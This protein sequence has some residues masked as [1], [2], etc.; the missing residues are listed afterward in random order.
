LER[1]SE[2][3]F[4]RITDDLAKANSERDAALMEL[5]AKSKELS[6]ARR[7]LAYTE[8]ELE[9]LRNGRDGSAGRQQLSVAIDGPRD[10]GAHDERQQQQQQHH[11]HVPRGDVAQ[12]SLENEGRLGGG[13]SASAPSFTGGPGSIGDHLISIGD[14][15]STLRNDV[16]GPGSQT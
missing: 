4:A 14:R 11:H 7:D 6:G 8:G 5:E 1:G 3:A 12:D 9:R 16:S 2:G 13:N 15:L 10:A